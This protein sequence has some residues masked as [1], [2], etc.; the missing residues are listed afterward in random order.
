MSDFLE[1][2]T[3][4]WGDQVSL[5]AHNSSSSSLAHLDKDKD[6]DDVEDKEREANPSKV[7]DKDEKA[8]DKE[9][10]EDMS[11]LLAP[12]SSP[13]SGAPATVRS[14]RRAARA[15][16]NAFTGRSRRTRVVSNAE[17]VESSVAPLGPLDKGEEEGSGGDGAG[18]SGG[19]GAGGGA[20]NSGTKG[21]GEL[22][23]VPLDET[24]MPNMGALSVK[25]NANNNDDDQHKDS[26]DGTEGHG[27]PIESKPCQPKFEITVGD[28]IK[29]GDI[30]SSHTVYT[31]HTSTNA[32]GFSRPDSAVTRRYRDFRW[33]FHALE[34][35]NPGVIV[36]PPPEKQALGRFKE[37]FVE[38]RRSALQVMLNKIASHPVLHAD[39][40]LRLFLESDSFAG[41]VKAKSRNPTGLDES[42]IVHHHQPPPSSS[43]G[44]GS[45]GGF[46][47]TLGGAFSFSGKFVETNEWFVEK[48]RYVDGLEA[49][50]KSLAKALD[51]VV[52]QRRELSDATAE[53]ALSLDTL[54]GVEISK[55]LSDILSNFADAHGKIKDLYA[56]QCM[57]DI[58]SLSNT[59]D[60]YIRL[61]GSIRSVFAQR[62]RAYLNVQT[63]EH[64]L[65]KKRQHLDKLH[66]QGKTLQDKI[67]ALET[68]VQDQEKRVVNCRVAFDDISKQIV[69]EFDR[70]EHDKVRDFRNSVELFL[71]NAVEAQKEAIEVW[72]TFYQLAGFSAPEVTA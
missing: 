20:D 69:S 19:G 53:F 60:E 40:D 45:G 29:V 55:S 9:E 48:K 28:P 71:E 43:S 31:V 18:T 67:S 70:F 17:P 38:S 46:M 66:R 42:V 50:L 15:K 49:Q 21:S 32:P 27:G 22:Q 52:T 26:Y 33:L 13:P 36:P 65:S 34:A 37:D 23:D 12:S 3:S 8:E 5:S 62:Q 1:D 7:E 35:N 58:M 16:T 2:G 47:S 56:R 6:R 63:A 61:I 39:P 64:D 44:S 41:D 57:Q 30:T 24:A 11:K 25:D 72:E 59:L 10:K 14:P 4:P 54:G 51:L 68:E